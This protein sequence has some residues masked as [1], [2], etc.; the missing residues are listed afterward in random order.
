[1]KDATPT[2]PYH[3]RRRAAAAEAKTQRILEA[4]LGLFGER[5]VDQITLAAVAERAGVGLQTVIRR[6]STKEGLIRAVNAW[7]AD[8]IVADRGE[9]GSADPRVVADAMARHYERWADVTGRALRQEDASP[10]LAENLRA[11]RVAHRE[12]IAAAFA[13]PLAA[14]DPDAR[15]LLLARLAAVCGAELW[16][17]LRR[18]QGLSAHEAR[19]TVAGLLTACLAA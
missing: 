8:Q 7:V 13:E 6:V 14:R 19:D 3:Q 15:R 4:T 11:G 2:R 1:M 9:P 5:P 16:L 10:A 12:W 17:V 18:D